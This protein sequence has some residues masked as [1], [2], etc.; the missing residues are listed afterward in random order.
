MWSKFNSMIQH[1]AKEQLEW[2]PVGEQWNRLADVSES[3]MDK[4]TE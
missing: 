3:V 4:H 1:Y 2:L